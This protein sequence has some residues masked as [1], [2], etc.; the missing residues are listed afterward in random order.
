MESTGEKNQVFVAI[1][2]LSR[3]ERATG[4][5]AGACT[6][7]CCLPSFPRR[8]GLLARVTS[9]RCAQIEGPAWRET[10]EPAGGTQERGLQGD[11]ERMGR[12]ANETGRGPSLASKA[13]PVTPGAIF[14]R[15]ICPDRSL[16]A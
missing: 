7:L 6:P 11:S 14:V 10:D 3:G 16:D 2:S 5:A 9:R 1:C 12:Q 13:V 15:F 8:A 4:F